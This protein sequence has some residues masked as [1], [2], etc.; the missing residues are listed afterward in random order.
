M[1]ID[2]TGA[3]SLEA[4]S[5]F[6][7]HIKPVSGAS[8][9]SLTGQLANLVQPPYSLSVCPSPWMIPTRVAAHSTWPAWNSNFG[10]QK[11]GPK[12]SGGRW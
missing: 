2:D 3:H 4:K 10:G 9:D 1:A 5:S 6:K 12:R 7:N 11:V 8:D